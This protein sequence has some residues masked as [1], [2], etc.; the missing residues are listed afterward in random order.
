VRARWYDPVTRRFISPDPLG[1]SAG[2][3]QYAFA[4]GD[5]IDGIDPTG[6]L[7]EDPDDGGDCPLEGGGGG[8]GGGGAGGGYPIAGITISAPAC[9]QLPPTCPYGPKDWVAYFNQFDIFGNGLPGLVPSVNSFGGGG[10]GAQGPTPSLQLTPE[11]KQFLKCAA[12]Q[13]H[14]FA[15]AT[16]AVTWVATAVVGLA[17]FTDGCVEGG[18]VG[19]FAFTPTGPGALAGGLG[20]CLLVG[21]TQAYLAAS[22]TR[23]ASLAVGGAVLIGTAAYSGY[24]CVQNPE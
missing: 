24:Q 11:A 19:F 5:P 16:V 15:Q 12:Q 4:G 21:G 2:I 7:C 18:A 1:L 23:T 8:G 6:L 3:N 17:A 14:E 13:A 10:S 22:A 20:G 9:N